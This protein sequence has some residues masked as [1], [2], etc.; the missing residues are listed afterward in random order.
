MYIQINHVRFCMMSKNVNVILPKNHFAMYQNEKKIAKT[1]TQCL[2]FFF[3]HMQMLISLILFSQS[4]SANVEEQNIL[5][6]SIQKLVRIER[7]RDTFNRFL[8]CDQLRKSP[9][10]GNSFLSPII[11]FVM[12]NIYNDEND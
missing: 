3:K 2:H 6:I 5:F 7:R 4:I 12:Y 10:R 1:L 9:I 11:R 8:V